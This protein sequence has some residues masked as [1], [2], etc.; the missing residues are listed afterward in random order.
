LKKKSK[1]NL[2]KPIFLIGMMGSWKTTVGKLAASE[3][4]LEFIDIDEEIELTEAKS[5]REIFETHGKEHFRIIE[6]DTLKR[7]SDKQDR[8]IST[9]GGI[10]LNKLNRQIMSK[11]GPTILLKAE[12]KTIKHRIRNV[13]KRPLLKHDKPLLSQLESIWSERRSFYEKT[14]DH[15]IITDDLTPIEVVNEISKLVNQ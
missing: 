7:I 1:I 2:Q 11:N 15:T 4:G 5:I 8:I 3:L 12:P 10:V 14:A 6:T 13:E 9:G